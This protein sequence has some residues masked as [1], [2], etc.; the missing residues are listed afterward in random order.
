M[1]QEHASEPAG[2]RYEVRD[3][4]V[5]RLLQFG[6]S[7]CVVIVLVLFGMAKLMAYL[8]TR[9]PGGRPIS[10]LATTQQLPPSPRLQITPRLDLAQKREAE[11]AVLNSYAWID[12]SNG[13]VR[14]PIDRAM[15]LIAAR[16]QMSRDLATDVQ[17]DQAATPTRRDKE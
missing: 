5:R 4:N 6:V 12:R 10:P 17:H 2:P 16:P 13:T 15:E 3:A 9:Q 7:L 8:T 1:T 11:N 14:I